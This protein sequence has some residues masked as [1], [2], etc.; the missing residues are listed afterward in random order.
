MSTTCCYQYGHCDTYYQGR[1]MG[2]HPTV[3]DGIVSRQVYF[4]YYDKHN[5]NFY[6][7]RFSIYIKVRNCGPFYVYKLKPT[8]LIPLE[9]RLKMGKTA[10]FKDATSYKRAKI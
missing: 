4:G 1:L 7:N 8:P 3:D 9:G 6:K 2:G 5:V 10:K